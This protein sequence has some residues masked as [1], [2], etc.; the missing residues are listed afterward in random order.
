M[1]KGLRSYPKERRPVI[2]ARR[3]ATKG[4]GLGKLAALDYLDRKSREDAKRKYTHAHN[5]TS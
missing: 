2:V 1:S 3:I 4:R 5:N